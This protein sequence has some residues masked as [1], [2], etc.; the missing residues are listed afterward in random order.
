MRY[1]FCILSV[2][3]DVLD[4]GELC[5]VEMAQTF[6]DA[7]E[8]VQSLA[9]LLPG[10]FVIYDRETGECVSVTADVKPH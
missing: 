3:G 8:R 4:D 7:K 2:I 5:F 9:E 6:D 10:D 1:P